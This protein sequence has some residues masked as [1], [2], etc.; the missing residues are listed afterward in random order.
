MLEG[1]GQGASEPLGTGAGAGAGAAA[2]SQPSVPASQ[3]AAPQQSS[4]SASTPV[5]APVSGEQN[6]SLR[7][8]T[9]W[10]PPTAAGAGNQGVS[11]VLETLRRA[12][13]ALA[14]QFQS[15]E[16]ALQHLVLA[17]RQAQ[18]AQQMAPYAQMYL[19]HASAF[20]EF[21]QQKQEA[22]R[23]QA[24]KQ[25]QGWWKAPEYD[26][27]WVQAIERDPQTQQL[28]VKP[29]YAPD[30][31]AK[32]QAARDHSTQFLDKFA[33]NPIEA[34][35]P[36]LEDVAR[37]VAR[38]VVQ[39]SLGGY[40][41]QRTAETFLERNAGWMHAKD[42]QGRTVVHPQT[43]QP[44]L[45]A[46]GHRFAA[47]VNDAS[48]RGIHESQAQADY[49]MRMV[50]LDYY[51]L[52]AQPQQAAQAQQQVNRQF[53]DQH[54]PNSL[55]GAGSAD[56]NQGQSLQERLRRNMAAQGFK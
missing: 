12:D 21:L 30:V 10:T 13:P 31:L 7:T 55:S 46:W 27:A 51:R 14:A 49:A 15:D 56:A 5:S 18:Q 52:Q 23:Q 16:A 3:P 45:S 33:F 54:R 50:E 37:E 42:E 25:K 39:E 35:K 44:A 32:L 53:T 41:E 2:P 28:R 4:G 22:E 20:Q 19:Q 47:H 34:I 48:Q 38:Q 36:G 6:G 9:Q 43:G 40:Q 8:P 26:P 1:N 17:Q 29:G 24:L 11:S